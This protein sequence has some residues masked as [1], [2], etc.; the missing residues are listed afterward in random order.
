MMDTQYLDREN[1][2]IAYDLTGSGPLVICVPSMGDVRAEYRFLVP[3]LVAAGFRVATMDVRGHGQSS[4]AWTD[5]SVA[6][7]GSDIVALAARLAAG[8]AIVIGDSM[9]GG[10]TVWA[11]AEQPNLFAG[12]VLVDPFVRDFPASWLSKLYPLL[13][14][15]VWGSSVWVKYYATLYPSRK[16]ADFEAY[17]TAL[18]ANLREP[19][20][21]RALREMILASKAASAAALAK[22]KAPALVVMGARDPDFKDPRAEAAWVAGRLNAEVRLVDGAGHY[23]HAEMPAEFCAAVLPFLQRLSA[24]EEERVA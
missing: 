23:P 11:A 22:V 21:M 1:G 8:P 5:Y 20:R 15:D 12:L 13:F 9:A 7:V 24:V 19:G 3:Q 17:R 18:A 16:P 6:G 10:A 2:K 14:A 4:V